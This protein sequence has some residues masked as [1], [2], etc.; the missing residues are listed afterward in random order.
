VGRFYEDFRVGE[1]FTTPART[2]T[3]ADVSLFAGLSG[4]YNPVHTDAEYAKTTAFGQ[5]VAHGPLGIALV[6]GLLS[7]LG[8]FD[9]TAAASLGID[10]K[11]RGPILIGDT[12][13]V[14]M[15]VN[16]MRETRDPSRGIIVRDVQL[17]NQK[18]EVVQ[19]GTSTLMMLRN[20][21]AAP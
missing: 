19:E 10:W 9:G 8:I 21:T 14:E 20:G 3:E 4:D 11:F 1:K 12:L 5:R 15:S 17:V 6:S 13:H 18:G 2:I 7:R 16:S